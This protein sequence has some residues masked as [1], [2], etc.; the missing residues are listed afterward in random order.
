MSFNLHLNSTYT[1]GMR[2][3]GLGRCEKVTGVDAMIGG[4]GALL[5]SDPSTTSARALSALN[6]LLTK[7]DAILK[8]FTSFSGGWSSSFGGSG[9]PNAV[10]NHCVL[11]TLACISENVLFT[12][13]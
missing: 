5:G 9:K 6:S 12:F 3:A 10:L 13:Q 2:L 7:S 4:G 1:F 11:K 8:G